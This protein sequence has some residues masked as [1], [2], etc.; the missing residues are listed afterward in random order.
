MDLDGLYVVTFGGVTGSRA[1]GGVVVLK[2]RGFFGGDSSYYYVGNYDA[3]N[4]PLVMGR[5]RIVKHSAAAPNVF[6]DSAPEFEI[7]LRGRLGSSGVIRGTHVARRQSQ[8][9]AALRAGAQGT[10]AVAG[11]YGA[12]PS[13]TPSGSVRP[14][15]APIARTN[16]PLG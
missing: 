13:A 14:F 1:N 9:G 11:R 8:C 5:G 7:I 12:G 6:G 2:G 4:E 15:D 3:S 16:L 10:I